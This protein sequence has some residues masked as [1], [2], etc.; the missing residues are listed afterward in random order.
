MK[1]K[2]RVELVW[3][4]SLPVLVL[5]IVGLIAWQTRSG[6]LDYASGYVD[7]PGYVVF[8]HA[9]DRVVNG[10]LADSKR[11]TKL[12]SFL[13]KMDGVTGH[14][15][16][17]SV[18]D[19]SKVFGIAFTGD[20]GKVTSRYAVH[21]EKGVWHVYRMGK[22]LGKMELKT[23]ESDRKKLDAMVMDVLGNKN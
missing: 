10:K 5:V 13:D 11:V 12:R 21:N 23:S 9:G 22:R 17:G 3:S 16:Y 18:S 15:K 8:D 6:E 14:G 4:I 2:G 20:S 7:S 19:K 1:D